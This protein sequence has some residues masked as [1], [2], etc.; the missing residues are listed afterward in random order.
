LSRSNS[1][2]TSARAISL[3]N[4]EVLYLGLVVPISFWITINCSIVLDR[5]LVKVS[6]SS[7][8]KHYPLVLNSFSVAVDIIH[9]GELDRTDVVFLG[10]IVLIAWGENFGLVGKLVPLLVFW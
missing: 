9:N 8:T 6:V 7:V 5:N 2:K 1:I 3:G 4:D 10:A